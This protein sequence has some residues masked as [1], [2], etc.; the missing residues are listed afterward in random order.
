MTFSLECFEG[1]SAECS[2]ERSAAQVSLKLWH[3]SV[4][5]I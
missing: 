3:E 1:A 5:E 4:K 2:V